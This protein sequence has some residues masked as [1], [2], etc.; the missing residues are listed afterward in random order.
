MASQKIKQTGKGL[1][2]LFKNARWV[3]VLLGI[4]SATKKNS[5]QDE[6]NE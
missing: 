6:E 2:T 4:H 1:I 3:A 5:N